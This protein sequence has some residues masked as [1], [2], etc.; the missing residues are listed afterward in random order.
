[1]LAFPLSA[2][3]APASPEGPSSGN[4]TPLAFQAEDG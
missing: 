1:M 3:S 4:H 2:V